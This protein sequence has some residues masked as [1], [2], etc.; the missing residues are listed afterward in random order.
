[1]TGRTS[2]LEREAPTPYVE[3]HP[4]DAINLSINDGE[5]VK[6][7]SR[8][9]SIQLSAFLTERVAKGSCFIPFHYRE[10]AANVLTI[11][12]VDPIAKIPEYKV[13]AVK[14]EKL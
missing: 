12:E 11:N 2:T 3:L 7:T 6:V 1:M 10:A 9:G 4:Q 8:R 14:V 13:C 5:M